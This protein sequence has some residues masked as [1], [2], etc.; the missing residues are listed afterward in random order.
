MTNPNEPTNSNSAAASNGSSAN[1]TTNE[2]ETSVNNKV[3][4]VRECDVTISARERK[5]R[6]CLV[7]RRSHYR[8]GLILAWM[9][10]INAFFTLLDDLVKERRIGNGLALPDAWLEQ[11]Q[12]KCFPSH[13]KDHRK[14]PVEY[15]PIE[16][17]RNHHRVAPLQSIHQTNTLLHKYQVLGFAETNR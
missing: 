8:R 14:D 16:T 4:H 9:F 11:T 10:V 17:D 6:V 15:K 1:E 2:G 3:V 7:Y 5:D 12:T 13:T